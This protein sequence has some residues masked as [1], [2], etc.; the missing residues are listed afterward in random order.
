MNLP[1]GDPVELFA[2]IFNDLLSVFVS[3]PLTTPLTK[4]QEVMAN[5][6]TGSPEGKFILKRIIVN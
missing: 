4:T 5:N 3:G 2:I 1:S 6:S